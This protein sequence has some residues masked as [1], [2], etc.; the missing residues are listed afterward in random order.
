MQ[1]RR[2]DRER[3]DDRARAAADPRAVPPHGERHALRKMNV[4]EQGDRHF[5]YD[6]DVQRPAGDRRRPRRPRRRQG[7]HLLAS[8]ARRAATS[9]RR[10]ARAAISQAAAMSRIAG[11]SRF[12]GMAHGRARTVYIQTDDGT[13]HKAYETMVEGMRGKDPVR[14]K[15]YVDVDTGDDRRGLPADLLRREPQGLHGE[16]RH[17]PPRHA[18]AHRGPGRDQRRRRQR[19]VRRHRR[20]VRGVQ[21]LLEPRLVRQRGRDAHQLGPL[22]DRTT[23]TRTG[24]ATAD[25]VRRRRSRRRAAPRSRAR[26]RRDGARAHPRGDR[27]RVRPQLQR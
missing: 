4:D 20:H 17:A 1:T 27:A 14:D 9:R 25:G 15:V 19:G 2:R 12:A 6:A 24:T 10:S 8:T 22:L 16:R 11:D 5:R 3:G 23:A 18:Q 7:R 21:Q 26:S 13:L